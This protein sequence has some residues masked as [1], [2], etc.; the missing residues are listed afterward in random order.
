EAGTSQKQKVRST[1]RLGAGRSGRLAD[2]EARGELDVERLEAVALEEAHE[3]ADRGA[4]H[5]G[6]RLA[7][8]GER[9]RHDRRMLDVV[10]ADDGEILGNAQAAG[11]RG[12]DRADRVVVVEREDGGG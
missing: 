1:F 12:A 7:H 5:L 9:R 2:D 8:G 11:A 10:E 6:E 4:A 3:E